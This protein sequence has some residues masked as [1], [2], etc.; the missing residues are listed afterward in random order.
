M[1]LSMLA[2]WTNISAITSTSFIVYPR[3]VSRGRLKRDLN[4][5]DTVRT[6]YFH[7][8]G[9][10]LIS[11]LFLNANLITGRLESEVLSRNGMPRKSSGELVDR[12]S[13][14]IGKNAAI[15][16]CPGGQITGVLGKGRRIFTLE[17]LSVNG[18]LP[19]AHNFTE[20]RV[21][22]DATRGPP[23]SEGYFS[24]ILIQ[25]L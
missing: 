14:Y 11:N 24:H 20:V 8:G 13:Y 12:C 2:F 5:S 17:P 15:Q 19:C 3:L 9:E 4:G 10:S 23:Q 25:C 21:R 7:F 22:R 1:L 6:V 18:D 16:E